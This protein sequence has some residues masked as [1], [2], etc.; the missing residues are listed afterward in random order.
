MGVQANPMPEIQN[1]I[2]NLFT[3]RDR[4]ARG[5]LRKC[6]GDSKP[7]RCGGTRTPSNPCAT[8]PE[9]ARFPN[10]L[11]LYS[12]NESHAGVSV[13]LPA[14]DLA[15]AVGAK[16]GEAADKRAAAVKER[17]SPNGKQNP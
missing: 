12:A 17:L 10:V 11:G 14:A 15:V 13:C 4:L 7:T 2:H 16:R 6:F 8:C 3:C 9:A 5:E 1:Q